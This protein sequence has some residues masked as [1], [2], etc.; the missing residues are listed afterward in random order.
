MEQV[1]RALRVVCRNWLR[2]QRGTPEGKHTREVLEYHQAR[3]RAARLSRTLSGG[4][5][6]AWSVSAAMTALVV[7]IVIAFSPEM[8]TDAL[9]LVLTAL[10]VAGS[11][12]QLPVAF[13]VQYLRDDIDRDS[14]DFP[15]E[16]KFYKGVDAGQA[17][18]R[19]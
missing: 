19:F 9:V 18:A 11:W 4:G 14:L 1:C 3:N 5:A 16:S 10:M 13:A 6:T 12:L 7:A 17:E 2:R 8:R 15:G